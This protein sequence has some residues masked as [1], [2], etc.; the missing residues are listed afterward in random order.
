MQD[1]STG[2]GHVIGALILGLVVGI[3]SASAYWRY[4]D[5][6]TVGSFEQNLRCREIARSYEREHA[7]RLTGAVAIDQVEFSPTRNSC[8]AKA[9]EISGSGRFETWNYKV[10]DILT[11]DSESAGECYMTRG[12]CGGGNDIRFMGQ[13]EKLF[14]WFVTSNPRQ[15]S[16]F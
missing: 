2:R 7:D 5:L 10:I 16:P 11:N 1:T 12:E 8:I 4:R 14:E 9:V 3:L 15:K 6:K 13:Q